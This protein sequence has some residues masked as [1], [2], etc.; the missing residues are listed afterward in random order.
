MGRP[1]FSGGSQ[2]RAISW[3]SCSAV[4]LPGQ[5][6]RGSSLSSSSM[7]LRRAGGSSEHSMRMRLEKAYVSI[8]AAIQAGS[9]QG[10]T[11]G[12]EGQ[13]EKQSTGDSPT[14]A[15]IPYPAPPSAYTPA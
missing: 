8:V 4:N 5:P 3:V 13:G 9:A 6:G 1:D 14:P 11:D 12:D 10:R 2:A 7:A 15:V